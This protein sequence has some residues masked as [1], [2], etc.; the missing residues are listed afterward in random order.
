[1]GSFAPQNL[2]SIAWAFAKVG[3]RD[4]LLFIAFRKAL[5]RSFPV[6][7]VQETKE[8]GG[9]SRMVDFNARSLGGLWQSWRSFCF[10]FSLSFLTSIFYHFFFDFGWVLRVFWE[11]KMVEKSRFLVFFWICLWRPYFWS[12]FARFLIKSMVKNI[13]IFD[14]FPTRRFINCC[15]NLLISSMLET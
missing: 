7:G 14:A 9:M 12:K 10:V 2:A 15:L 6:K 13:G 11:A 5:E 8:A 4:A 1:M 3:Q